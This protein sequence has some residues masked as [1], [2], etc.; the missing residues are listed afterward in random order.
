[1]V[2]KIINS[3]YAVFLESLVIAVLILVI[4]FVFG[5]YVEYLR[6]NEM[7]DNYREFEVAALDLKL[8]NYYFQIMEKSD[9]DVAIEQ[10]FEF[11]DRVYDEGLRLE[12][13]EELDELNERTIL[14]ERKKYVLLKTELW[15]NSILLKDKCGD[16]FHTVVY[17]YAQ[18]QNKEQK[19]KQAVFSKTLEE[20]KKEYGNEIVLLPIAGDLGLNSVEMQKRAHN[21]T[22]LP[23]VLID[24]EIVVTGFES[25]QNLSQYIS[26]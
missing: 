11:A 5:Y 7:I 17:F 18:N 23:S 2:H 25:V 22:I 4:G 10:N 24:E 1:M 21:I 20:L 9:C 6:V 19:A 15:L 3:R 14:N 12:K 13:Y 16:P 26:S 8:Q